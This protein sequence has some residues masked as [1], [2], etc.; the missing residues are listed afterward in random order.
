MLWLQNFR[1][2]Y[3]DVVTVTLTKMVDKKVTEM[4]AEMVVTAIWWTILRQNPSGVGFLMCRK[5]HCW[6]VRKVGFMS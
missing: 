2:F 6:K 5:S 1:T 3:N 4:V